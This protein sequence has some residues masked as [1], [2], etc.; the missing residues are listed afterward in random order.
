MFFEMPREIGHELGLEGRNEPV[1][2]Y[3]GTWKKIQIGREVRT[4]EGTRLGKSA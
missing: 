3:C 1:H 2:K 4:K